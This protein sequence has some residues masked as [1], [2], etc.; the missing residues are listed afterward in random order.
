VFTKNEI[1]SKDPATFEWVNRRDAERSV[2]SFIRRNPLNYN[3]AVL[4]VISFSAT[5]YPEYPVGVPMG[6]FCRQVFFKL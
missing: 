6:G 5:E 1:F 2:I 4:A 3:G